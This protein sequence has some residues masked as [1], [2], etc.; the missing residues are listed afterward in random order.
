[1]YKVNISWVKSVNRLGFGLLIFEQR[2]ILV[3]FYGLIYVGDK[4][5]LCVCKLYFIS[6]FKDYFYI[7]YMVKLY[8]IYLN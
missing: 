7:L 3:N 1:M 6:I 5:I 8:V 4:N 2:C